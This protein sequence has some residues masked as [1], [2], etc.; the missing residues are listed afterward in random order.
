MLVYVRI[1]IFSYSIWHIYL[2][3]SLFI[4]FDDFKKIF[5][6]SFGLNNHYSIDNTTNLVSDIRDLVV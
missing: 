3:F 4:W 1:S 6:T 5:E 2:L